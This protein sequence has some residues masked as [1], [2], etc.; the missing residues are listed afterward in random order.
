MIRFK[1][2]VS[3]WLMF[4]FDIADSISGVGSSSDGSFSANL[5]LPLPP[6][7]DVQVDSALKEMLKAAR[8]HFGVDKARQQRAVCFADVHFI[9]EL[10][11]SM[12]PS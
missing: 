11:F 2:L 5:L 9:G 6:H 10:E 3:L 4:V 12:F 1:I 7:K 8:E